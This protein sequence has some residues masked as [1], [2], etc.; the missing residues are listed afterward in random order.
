MYIPFDNGTPGDATKLELFPGASDVYQL[1]KL[2]VFSDDFPDLTKWTETDADGKVNLSGGIVTMD[3]GNAYNHGLLCNTSFV[4]ADGLCFEIK[5]LWDSDVGSPNWLIGPSSVNSLVT[6]YGAAGYWGVWLYG[7]SLYQDINGSYPWWFPSPTSNIW[8]TIRQYV[9][10][11]K[12]GTWYSLKFTIQGGAYSDETTII[13]SERSNS[14]NAQWPATLYWQLTRYLSNAGSLVRFKEARVYSGL[15]T[16]G[17]PVDFVSDAGA[18]KT[19]DGFKFSTFA[20]PAGYSATNL[21]IGYVYS[22]TADDW[23]YGT[24]ATGKTL[25]EFNALTDLTTRKRYAKIRLMSG[26]DGA[27]QQYAPRPLMETDGIADLPDVGSVIPPDT[28]QLVEGTSDK[29]YSVVEEAARNTDMAAA[30]VELSYPYNTR[31]VA[32]VGE[33]STGLDVPDA[34]EITSA[35][36]LSPTSIRVNV[37]WAANAASIEIYRAAT[38]GGTYSLIATLT[39]GNYFDDTVPTAATDYFYKARGVNATGNG[40]YGTIVMGHSRANNSVE[41]LLW[42][43]F[44]TKM[45]ADVTL[46]AYISKWKFNREANILSESKFPLLK[47]WIADTSEDWKGVPKSKIVRC[48]VVIHAIVKSGT[49]VETEKL[50]ADEY[51]KNAVEA[52]MTFAGGVTMNIVGDTIFRNLDDTTVEIFIEVEIMSNRFTAGE[53]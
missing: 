51:I 28:V 36:G 14:L 52:D 4:R 42:S 10:L 20:L 15:S 44:K 25:A 45:Q 21:K 48:R 26:S 12:D 37:E 1:K 50:K 29:I 2:A 47:A 32:R 53:R 23:T 24:W 17:E 38:I 9:L 5:V 18:G 34:I 22:D 31:G 49:D 33:L 16:A 41:Q 43:T 46:A 3:G 39:D 19:H 13:E 35:D 30:K 27:T 6:A 40:T 11:D 7:G 8:Y